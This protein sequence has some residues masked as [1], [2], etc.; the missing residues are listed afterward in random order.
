MDVKPRP[1][2]EFGPFRLEVAEHKLLHGTEPVALTA[3]AFE[4]L[5]V[6]VQ[7]SE[8]LVEKGELIKRVW[9]DIF[10]DENT[11]TQNI[12]TV[13]KAL[14]VYDSSRQYIETVPRRGYRFLVRAREVSQQSLIA[15]EQKQTD[16]HGLASG[17]LAG[18]PDQSSISLGVLPL[19][20]VSADPNI[21]YL[22]E[23][24][25]DSLINNLSQLPQLR[26][27]S[28]SIVFRY[29]GSEIDP[30]E[31]G[32]ELGVK[33]VLLGRVQMIGDNLAVRTELVDVAGGWQIW[34]GQYNRKLSDIF[35]V[36]EDIAQQIFEKLQLKLIGAEQR[37]QLFTRHTENIEAYQLYLKG[38]YYWNKRNGEG[39]RIA[40]D[41]FKQ[42]IETDPRYALA[43][44]GLADAYALQASAFYGLEM[45][46]KIIPK[47]KAA[48]LKA[49]ELNDRLAEAHTS[50]AYIRLSYDWDLRGA[51]E[52]FKRAIELK[53]NYAY[54]HHW[55]A[56]YLMA[57][58]RFDESLSSCKRALELEPF[59]PILNLHIG[60]YYLYA[61]EY[62]NAIDQLREV[63]ELTPDFYPAHFLLGMAYAKQE[64]FQEALAEFQTAELIED[65]PPL[66][67]FVGYAHALAGERDK[68]LQVLNMLT[69]K[70]KHRYVPPY[71]WA[72]IYIALQ[73]ADKA[74]E[75]LNKAYEDRSEW[76]IWLNINPE[77]DSLRAD[78]RFADLQR[79]IGLPQ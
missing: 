54:A 5:V 46:R 39:Y 40:L 26:V 53:P 29:Q 61:R 20:N 32:K 7:N 67:G 38:R 25:T 10:V 48:V 12:F 3:K 45:P 62:D 11:L 24:I 19:V 9:P 43:Y 30:R 52:S 64:R 71:C 77:L 6:L 15:A 75:Y 13:R 22:C 66:L 41:C 50:L 60:W 56:H 8:R 73:D 49:L 44:T 78:P 33:A 42:A 65:C 69:E 27:V 28:R 21:D 36:Q 74:F 57:V 35:E 2:Y 63:V 76:M 37:P 31:V 59:D 4:T 55:Y 1:I 72:V 18:V 68:A 47:A 51:E 23:G 58:G 17:G 16:R 70:S 79:R 14:G 34:G